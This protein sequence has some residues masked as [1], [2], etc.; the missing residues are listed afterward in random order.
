[1][2]LDSV[3]KEILRILQEDARK[4]YA[5]IARQLRV[6]EGTIRF[7]V[8]RL[9]REGV[10][11]RF[12]ALIDPRKVG[13]QVTAVVMLRVEASSL[14]EVFN[15]LVSLSESQHVFQS[16]GEYDIVAI[17]HA[18]DLNHLGELVNRIK[19]FTGVRNASVSVITRLVRVDPTLKL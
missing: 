11:T 13:M 19:S 3:D 1:M 18:R 17:V 5:E 15:Q 2:R 6:T 7:R 4:P 9:L 12:M 14:G 10:V 8:A 16:T